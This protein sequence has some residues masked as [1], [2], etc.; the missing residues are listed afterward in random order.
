MV[1]LF[2]SVFL[3]EIYCMTMTYIFSFIVIAA[4]I[5]FSVYIR[6]ESN[7]STRSYF[8]RIRRQ[9]EEIKGIYRKNKED[10]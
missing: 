3:C 1:F 5:A 10:E 4:V 2:I 8:D 9:Q 6:N 7:E